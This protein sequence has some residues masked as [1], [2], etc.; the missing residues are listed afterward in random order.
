MYQLNFV[1]MTRF[2][3]ALPLFSIFFLFALQ[4]D[5]VPAQ[6]PLNQTDRNGCRIGEELR[7]GSCKLCRPGTYRFLGPKDV[8]TRDSGQC[9]TEQDYYDVKIEPSS[10]RCLPCPA[11]TYNPYRG[12]KT[13]NRCLSCPVGMTSSEGASRCR[14]CPPGKS[15][16][17][18]SPQCVTCS[19]G[20]FL[21]YPCRQGH[22]P[23]TACTKCPIGTYASETNSASCTKCPEG[24]STAKDGA[25]SKD[26]CKTCGTMGVRC[27]CQENREPLTAV[28]SYRPIGHS[29]CTRCPPGTRALTPFAISEKECIPCP[30]GTSLVPF[31]GCKKCSPGESSFGVGADYCRKNRDDECPGESFK[32]KSGVCKLCPAG[33]RREGLKCVRC[34]PG[35]VSQG[36][37]STVCDKCIFP[38]V[39]PPNDG[40]C[41]CGRNYF[42]DTDETYDC[43]PCPKGTKIEK[44]FHSESMCEPDCENF[45]DQPLCKPCKNDFERDY[46][47]GLCR[48]CEKG[49]RSPVGQEYCADPRTG[50]SKGSEFQIYISRF[51]YILTCVSFG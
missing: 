3:A 24:T 5:R 41:S 2:S 17:S 39:A 4:V 37:S 18:G 36:H 13:F 9:L 20:F 43:L 49:M 32:D 14:K 6:I 48:K 44:E 22:A 26:N 38:E 33:Y 1:N 40:F 28:V 25:T 27:S 47:T 35:S 10:T 42:F 34:L 19:K 7:G 11:G 29:V 8:P 15:S 50:C 31:E 30:D 45:P 23:D 12:V 46:D 21:T 51:G 16:A